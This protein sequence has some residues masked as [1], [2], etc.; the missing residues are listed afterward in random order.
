MKMNLRLGKRRKCPVP[1]IVLDVRRGVGRV[2]VDRAITGAVAVAA[3]AGAVAKPR[4]AA[5][6]KRSMRF[7]FIYIS[8]F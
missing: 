4:A 6:A 3:E 1:I 5:K 8:P 2:I 7:I